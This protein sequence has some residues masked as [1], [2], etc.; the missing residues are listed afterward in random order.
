MIVALASNG[1]NGAAASLAQ[2]LAAL[3]ASSGNKVLFV[4]QDQRQPQLTSDLAYD[5]VVIDASSGDGDGGAALAVAGVIVVLI[6]P[7]ELEAQH[8]AALLQRI[9]TAIDANPRAEVLV[10]V[11]HGEQA[12]SAHEVGNIL[13]FV[14][15]LSSARLADTL[16][17]DENGAYHP[18]HGAT[19]VRHLYGQV[20]RA[21]YRAN[22][23]P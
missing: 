4:K 1:N 5:D 6:H 12:L 18:R 20:F 22:T 10:A 13:V 21:P 16:V 11:S 8:D 3:R 15:Q 2:A 14:A 23:S 7:A 19:E 17:L 9:K